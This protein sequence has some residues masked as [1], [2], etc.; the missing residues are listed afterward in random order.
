MM[1]KLKSSASQ[2]QGIFLISISYFTTWSNF[3]AFTVY[4]V[5]YKVPV[6][7]LT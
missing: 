2:A 7:Y 6:K 3:G 4:N 5:P 1:H